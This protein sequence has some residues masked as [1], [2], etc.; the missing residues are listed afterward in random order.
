MRHSPSVIFQGQAHQF[1]GPLQARDGETPIFAQ[2]YVLDPSM[3]FTTRCANLSVPPNIT[4]EERGELGNILMDLQELLKR[5]NPYIKDYLQIIDILDE[6]LAT[7]WLVISA[8]ARPTGEHEHRYNT[9]VCLE[10]VSFLSK[11]GRH[12]LVITKRD[13]ALKIVSEQNLSAMPLHF[14]LLFPSG[15]K[16]WHPDLKQS[17]D[18]NKRLTTRDFAIFHLAWREEGT[19]E[20]VKHFNLIHYGDWLLQ[21]FIVI[22]YKVAVNMELNW[23]SL[24]QEEL[25]ADTYKNVWEHVATRP[26]AIFLDDNQPTWVGQKILPSTHVGGLR[27]YNAKF[28]DG[29]AIVKKNKKPTY[30]IT[31]T[32]NPHWREIVDNLGPSQTAQ[33]RPHLVA[34][35]FNMKKAQLIHDLTNGS[36]FGSPLAHMHMVKYQKRGLPHIHILLILAEEDNIHNVGDVDRV[37]CAE[38]PPD[39]NEPGISK[40]EKEQRSRLEHIV[41][42]NMIHGPCSTLFPTAD[43]MKDAKC[44]KFFPKPFQSRIVVDANA[45]YASYRRRCP[46]DG[47]RTIQIIRKGITYTADNSM[48]VP[49]NP[50]LLLQ[51]KCHINVEKCASILGA[52]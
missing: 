38:L 49:Y 40:E 12:D 1:A 19:V 10:E 3:E 48:V 21:E 44:K 25:Q 24:N 11:N 39:P 16:G 41:V 22:M 5:D 15:T 8:S 6:Q 47:G 50:L 52:K 9:P 18:S 32:C 2:L 23:M 17:P 13:G 33:N 27:W 46:S 29:M 51:Y 43:C 36:I 34:R 35:V 37:I 28:L 30:F 45:T 14:T 20:G 31:M 4:D 42:T 7:G 26:D